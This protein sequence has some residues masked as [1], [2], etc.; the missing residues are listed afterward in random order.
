MKNNHLR[1]RNVPIVR[2][3]FSG[4]FGLS[5]QTILLKG[6]FAFYIESRAKV[7]IAS[8]RLVTVYAYQF[9]QSTCNYS[10][11]KTDFCCLSSVTSKYN[12]LGKSLHTC[13]IYRKLLIEM[14]LTKTKEK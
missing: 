7:A 4:C 11:L 6:L 2:P 1:C 5:F 14:K 12:A 9:E 3:S 8:L 10:P 13:I